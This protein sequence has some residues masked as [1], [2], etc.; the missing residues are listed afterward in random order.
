MI[1]RASLFSYKKYYHPIRPIKLIRK[2]VYTGR[3]RNSRQQQQQHPQQQHHQQQPQPQPQHQQQQQTFQH[4]QNLGN[5]DVQAP[6]NVA[7]QNP[8]NSERPPVLPHNLTVNP[9]NAS[10]YQNPVNQLP[11]SQ[12]PI[13]TVPYYPTDTEPTFQ[14]PFYPSNQNFPYPYIPHSDITDGNSVNHYPPNIY[15]GGENYGQPYPIYS[16]YVYPANVYPTISTQNTP[17]NWY[18]VP[19]QTSTVPVP[20]YVQYSPSPT[21]VPGSPNGPQSSNVSK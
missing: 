10:V 17:E 6:K 7:V 9:G 19:G 15:S 13:Y 11:F 4:Q 1:I 16:P 14:S 8:H 3:Y 18:A 21:P 5:I 12:P 2:F 20:H